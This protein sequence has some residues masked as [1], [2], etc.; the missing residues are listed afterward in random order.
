[1]RSGPLLPKLSWKKKST[2]WNAG[3]LPPGQMPR[4][5]PPRSI[6]PLDKTPPPGQTI[7]PVSGRDSMY[8]VYY[9]VIDTGIGAIFKKHTHTYKEQ[10]MVR[11]WAERVYDTVQSTVLVDGWRYLT[12]LCCVSSSN[13]LNPALIRAHC[14]LQTHTACVCVCRTKWAGISHTRCLFM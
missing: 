3:Q 13:H 1:M 12:L 14:L 5:L 10:H 6:A 2:F 7:L 9:V 11:E 8:S 4:F